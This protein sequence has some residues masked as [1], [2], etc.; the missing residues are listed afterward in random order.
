MNNRKTDILLN[1]ASFAALVA[2]VTMSVPLVERLIAAVWLW[3][4]Y[5]GY[6]NDGHITLSLS[7][8]LI[9]SALLAVVFGC[10]FWINRFAKRHSATFAAAWSLRA[11][12]AAIAI[13]IIYWQ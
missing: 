13:A 12:Y 6:S 9:Y 10:S 1:I 7:T 3:Y 2:V 4:K 5:A 8:G 11:M